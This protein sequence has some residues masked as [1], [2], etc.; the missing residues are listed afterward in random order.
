MTSSS[1]PRLR[2]ILDA[3]PA[4]K[5]GQPARVLEGVTSYKL[6]SNENPFPPLPEIVQAATTA[7]ASMQLYPDFASTQLVS[8]LGKRFNVPEA[9]LAVATGS[10][11]LTQQLVNITSEPGDSVMFA[12]RSFESYPIVT[13]IGGANP[14]RVALD[15]DDRHDLDAMLEAIDSTTRLIFVCNPN[16]PTGT[17]VG[18]KPLADFLSK[19]PS[20]VLV[21]IDEAYREFVDPGKIPDGLDFYRDYANVAVLR[22]FSKAYGLAGLRVGFCIAHEPVAEALRKVQIPFGVSSVAQ[23]AGIAALIPSVEKA[24]FARCEN[25]VTERN[26][27]H[28]ALK[29][30]GFHPSES[31]ANFVWLRLGEH[32]S[33]FAESC[34]SAGVA[35]RPFAGEGVRVSVGLPE[36]NDQFVATAKIWLAG[37]Q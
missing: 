1:G 34:E 28:E 25:L 18:S 17:A 11:A 12:W 33:A 26:R 30:V 4:Y 13:M 24:A 32:T 7:A 29:A 10:V 27:V 8:A 2:P 22:T 16:N 23:A 6:S 5:A 19:V 31:E 21:V 3:I 36:A 9:H 14:V 15:Q 20:D 35:V 37:Q